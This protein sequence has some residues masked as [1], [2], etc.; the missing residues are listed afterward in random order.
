MKAKREKIERLIEQIDLL[1]QDARDYEREFESDLAEVH[2]RFRKS[3][4]NLL[5]YR[6][7]R[8]HDIRDLQM[9]L[10]QLGLSRLARAQG[11]M[12]ASLLGTR[13]ILEAIIGNDPFHFAKTSVSIKRG[14]KLLRSHTKALF[15]NRSKGRRVRIMVTLPTEAARDYRLVHELVDAGMNSARINCA[16]DDRA[17]W[18]AMI[19]NVRQASEQQ[20]RNVKVCM[21][22][23]GPKIR[24]GPIEPGPR[25]LCSAPRR[26]SFGFVKGPAI[27]WL[28]PGEAEVPEETSVR[29]PVSTEWVNQLQEGDTVYFHDTRRKERHFLVV[30]KEMEGCWAHGFDRAFLI[31]GTTLHVNSWDAEGEPVGELTPKEEKLLL[32]VGERLILHKAPTEGESAEVDENGNVIRPAHLSCTNPDVF[33]HVEVNDRVRFDDGKIEGRVVSR[34]P[35]EQLEIELTYTKDEGQRLGADKGINFPDTKL[36]TRGL[37]AKD[38]E[39]LEFVAAHADVVNMSFVN[40]PDDVKDLIKE[41]DRLGA[42][43]RVG[44]VLKIET[45]S[46]FNNLTEILLKAMQIHPVGVMIARGDLAVETGWENMALIQEEILGLCQAAHVPEVWATQVLETLAKKGLPSRAEVTDAASSLQAECVMLNKGPHIVRAVQM[47]DAILKNMKDY[48]HDKAPMLP[49]LTMAT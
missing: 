47:L 24:T 5:H 37:T 17:T 28:G 13:S 11:H 35:G 34:I 26:D 42:R 19:G 33:D 23:G 20:R 29:I 32:K 44:V 16:H 14:E 21:D 1:V 6:A 39:D 49:P 25:V 12:L 22:L 41:L 15:G 9:K 2:P 18:A 43:D 46:G 30:R 31:T 48:R 38:R 40:T 45:Q 36:K 4:E 8:R 10:G 3:A 27:V 7:V